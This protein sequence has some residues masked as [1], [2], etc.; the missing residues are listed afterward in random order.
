MPALYGGVISSD[1]SPHLVSYPCKHVQQVCVC[2]CYRI[3]PTDEEGKS[4]T[5]EKMTELVQEAHQA[6]TKKA[7]NG[8]KVPPPLSQSLACSLLASK[9]LIMQSIS[10]M[11]PT[12]LCSVYILHGMWTASAH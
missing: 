6:H 11:A 2:V 7:L 1:T 12:S 9:W 4:R 10:C 8:L 5:A 3:N